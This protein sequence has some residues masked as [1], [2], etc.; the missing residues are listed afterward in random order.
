MTRLILIVNDVPA[1]G[2]AQKCLD[3]APGQPVE[4]VVCAPHLPRHASRWLTPQQRAQWRDDWA[5]ALV[6]PWRSL[7]G[8]TGAQQ[9]LRYTLARGRLSETLA[10]LQAH[11]GGAAAA[12]H[13]PANWPARVQ[14][15][16]RRRAG[17]DLEPVS[18]SQS[19][20]AHRWVAPLMASSGLSALLFLAD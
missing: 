19:P 13:G 6:A 12:G 3:L 16:R 8:P 1:P 7:W 20:L 15:L 17:A 2:D 10:R 18:A 11:D 4:L 14:D 9:A 5:Q